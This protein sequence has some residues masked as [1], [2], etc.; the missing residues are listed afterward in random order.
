MKELL[1]TLVL[2][3]NM[4]ITSYRSVPS[5][6]DETPFITANGGFVHSN[7]VAVSRDLHVRYGGTLNFGS[8]IYIEN[9]GF[10]VVNDL[11]ADWICLDRPRPQRKSDCIKR[12]YQR[13]HIDIW[14]ATYQEEK[15]V[16]WKMGKVWLIKTN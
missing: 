4:Q 14:V 8:I 12:K 7:G 16:G 9:Y 3:G 11:M 13:R 15:A 10:K 5:Q 1:V 6:T 2:L